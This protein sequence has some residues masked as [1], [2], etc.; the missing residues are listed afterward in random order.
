MVLPA[1]PPKLWRKI[2]KR[3]VAEPRFAQAPRYLQE[4]LRT[5]LPLCLVSQAFLAL[6]RELLYRHPLIRDATT[7][8]LLCRTLRIAA[9]GTR[10]LVRAITFGRDPRKGGRAWRAHGDFAREVLIQLDGVRLE[11]V[12][13]K[14]LRLD[15]N[16]LSL[17]HS[18]PCTRMRNM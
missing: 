11:S 1:L 18:K 14:C 5:L 9:P 8:E 17:C 16:I 2:I 13:F 10:E 7:A 12:G 3:T 6:T 15:S 4:R